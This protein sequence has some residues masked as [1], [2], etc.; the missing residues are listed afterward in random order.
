MLA[1]DL[2]AFEN[3]MRKVW[4]DKETEF[5]GL[6]GRVIIRGLDLKVGSHNYIIKSE[7]TGYFLFNKIEDKYT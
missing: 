4:R 7:H 6:D 2:I 1:S 3:H 5:S